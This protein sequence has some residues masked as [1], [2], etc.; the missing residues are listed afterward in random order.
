[1]TNETQV[2]EP[3]SPMVDMWLI[4]WGNP[5]DGLTFEGPFFSAD[6]ATG[7]AEAAKG[8]DWCIAP[9]ERPVTK[10]QTKS[11]I[12]R[13]VADSLGLKVVEMPLAICD[14]DMVVGFPKV[15]SS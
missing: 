8:I 7:A 15:G 10:Q 1:M 2:T 4:I 13:E 9:I 3:V 6:D 14:V 5:V 11:E 12:M